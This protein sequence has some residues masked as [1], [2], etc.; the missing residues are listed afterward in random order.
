MAVAEQFILNRPKLIVSQMSSQQLLALQAAL[1]PKM[2]KYF[3]HRPTP[4]Q[5]AFLL[6]DCKEAFYGGAAGGGKSDA[7]L[8]AALQY[9]DVPGYAAILF[10]KTFSD[11]ALP[12]A[13]LDRAREWLAPYKNAG[14]IR[15]DER[16]K[17]Y[18]FP[19]GATLTF[20]YLEHP[21]DKYRYQGAE[22]QFIG[23]DEATQIDE[24]A[25]RY[26]FSR[27]RRLKGLNVP[28]R[29]RAASNPGGIGHE[30]VKRRFLLEGPKK[31]R[32][33]IPATLNDNPYLDVEQ[34]MES[35]GELDLITRAQLLEGNWEVREGGQL[36]KRE[37]FEIVDR[38]PDFMRQV[39]F[40]D[41][42]ATKPDPN[43]D[44]DW[45]VGLKLG[46]HKGIYIILDVRSTRGRPYSV[47]QMIK[48]TAISD[49]YDV[50]IGMEQ[51]PGSSGIITIDHYARNVLNGWAF[52]GYR[53]T[54]SKVIRAN[55][56]SAAAEQGRVKLLRGEWN[57]E[58]LDQIEMFPFGAHDDH[59][60]A[61]SGAFNMLRTQ[62]MLDAIPTEVGEGEGSY[63]ESLA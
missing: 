35:L 57:T 31:G 40:W 47:E 4:K 43:K 44:P 1:T 37:W 52:K 6:L 41:L 63:W 45:T 55:P 61:F 23:F 26:L 24:G 62:P 21:T 49:G 22:F 54:G 50:A 18:T 16:N 38:V 58:F 14:E 19:S 13:L 11:L 3:Y 56:A 34:Y 32:I 7:L 2:T 59:T 25:Y 46:E 15:W 29:M 20:G 60:D 9:V 48:A 53:S 8:M 5:T 51:E 36:F 10:R 27:L 42:A 28:L 17:T 12:G 33:F 39:R 30:W